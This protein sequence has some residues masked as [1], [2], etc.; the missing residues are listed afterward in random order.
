MDLKISKQVAKESAEEITKLKNKI[1]DNK[2]VHISLLYDTVKDFKEQNHFAKKIIFILCICILLSL[3]GILYININSNKKLDKLIN[4][5]ELQ[6]CT[7]CQHCN[8]I[9]NKKEEYD[10]N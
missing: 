7:R 2:E 4:T 3:V 5:V 1:K 6:Y 8:N 9:I 10:E